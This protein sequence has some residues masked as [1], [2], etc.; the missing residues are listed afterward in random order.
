MFAYAPPGVSVTKRRPSETGLHW[1]LIPY[2]PARSKK[3][4]YFD[5]K[6][7]PTA[8][9]DV[10]SSDRYTRSTISDEELSK[11]AAETRCTSMTIRINIPLFDDWLIEASNPGGLC[12]GH[13]FKAIHDSLR[14]PLTREERTRLLPPG[15]ERLR[16]AQEAFE[17]RCCKSAV[18]ISARQQKNGMLRIDLLG[19][20]TIFNGIKRDLNDVNWVLELGTDADFR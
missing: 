4:F 6:D 2:D 14:T 3:H 8:I 7:R 12:C 18:E 20:R 16:K 17:L 19:E 5:V 9:I 1:Q 13:V 11:P 15:S 10:S